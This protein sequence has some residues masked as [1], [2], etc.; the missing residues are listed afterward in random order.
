MLVAI[1]TCGTAFM[2][3]SQVCK[4][5]FN[6]QSY[7]PYLKIILMTIPISVMVTL[8]SNILRMRFEKW[9]YLGMS[10]GG[11][12]ISIGLT[13]LF[14]I[15]FKMGLKGFFGSGLVSSAIFFFVG[16]PLVKDSIGINFSWR[17]FKE[18]LFYGLPLVPGEV[19]MWILTFSD[20]YFLVNFTTKK[21][22]G[23]YSIGYKLST[24]IFLATGAFRTAWGPFGFHVSKDEDVKE[25]YADVLLYYVTFLSVACVMLGLFAREVL[26]I[27]TPAAYYAGSKVA[28]WLAMGEIFYGILPIMGMG[29]RL[30]KNTRVESYAFGTAAFLNIILNYFLIRNFGYMG[31]AIATVISFFVADIIIYLYGQ[32]YYPV[33][34]KIK[35][36]LMIIGLS[37]AT[38]I[39]GN[40]LDSNYVPLTPLF[41]LLAFSVFIGLMF[42]FGALKIEYFR[43]GY[44]KAKQIAKSRFTG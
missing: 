19:S 16:F 11:S 2:F 1:L 6:D 29:I 43:F 17:R 32:H 14:V 8:F 36:I 28:G 4:I 3:A 20:R 27:L 21:A 5:L 40:F 34:Y 15:T 25:F 30:T 13:L 18:M 41:K 38:I 31:A 44:T 22:V 35:K 37:V 24:I 23:L 39:S 10:L 42:L 12:I 7:L 33:P 9:K 26:I